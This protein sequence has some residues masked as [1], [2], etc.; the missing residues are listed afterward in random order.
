V[1]LEDLLRMLPNLKRLATGG[2]LDDGAV[3]VCVV[4][5]I[6]YTERQSEY[7]HPF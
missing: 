2:V 7:F 6:E 1:A 3:A 5:E 4:K